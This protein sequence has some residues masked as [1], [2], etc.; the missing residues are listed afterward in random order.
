MEAKCAVCGATGLIGSGFEMRGK[1]N[2]YVVLKCNSCSSGLLVKNAGRA[3]IT[4]KAKTES[5][6]GDLWRRMSSEW[7]RNFPSGNI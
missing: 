2:G 7:E 3:M 6:D 5:I 1:Y 4:K